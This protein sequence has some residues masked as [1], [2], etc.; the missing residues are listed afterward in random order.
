MKRFILVLVLMI[1]FIDLMANEVKT[2]D[3]I[4]VKKER[5]VSEGAYILTLKDSSGELT[6]VNVSQEYY[7]KY[8]LGERFNGDALDEEISTGTIIVIL[9]LL[10]MIMMFI[11]ANRY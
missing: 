1:P 5:D 3:G 9:S 7:R 8:K 4:I 10:I 2:Y 11:S 6:V